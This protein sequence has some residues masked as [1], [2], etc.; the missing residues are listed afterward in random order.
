MKQKPTTINN[1]QNLDTYTVNFCHD[2][3]TIT[4]TV[5]ARNDSDAE[6]VAENMLVDYYGFNLGKW[7]VETFRHQ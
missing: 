4:A 1:E 5:N 2:Y 3:A 7:S 6:T